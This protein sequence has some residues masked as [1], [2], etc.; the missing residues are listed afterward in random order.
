MTTRDYDSDS[1]LCVIQSSV[2][3]QTLTI[4][5]NNGETITVTAP[6]AIFV[7]AGGASG[8][9]VPATV[10]IDLH[11]DSLNSLQ[12]QGRV[13]VVQQNG[14]TYGGYT[15]TTSQDR[16]GNPLVIQQQSASH[17]LYLPVLRRGE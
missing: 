3:T 11:P 15:L 4:S 1:D 10:E 13:R 12:G 8:L 5:L 2:L 14:C 6:A 16:L 7:A 17:A 9:P